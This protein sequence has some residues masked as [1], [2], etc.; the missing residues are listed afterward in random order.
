MRA[1]LDEPNVTKEKDFCLAEMSS[2]ISV[3]F[4]PFD[5]CLAI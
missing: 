3:N 1:V 2:K 5:H 4:G